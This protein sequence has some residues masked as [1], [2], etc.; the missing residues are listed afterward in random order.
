MQSQSSVY[1]KRDVDYR[2]GTEPEVCRNCVHFNKSE[3]FKLFSA[4][5][6][7][8]VKGRIKEDYLCNLWSPNDEVQEDE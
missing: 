2:Q 6:C 1:P 8:L 7:D 3:G 4:G 5:S